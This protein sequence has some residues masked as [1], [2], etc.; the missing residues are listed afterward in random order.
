MKKNTKNVVDTS[1][2]AASSD[3]A[4]VN[5]PREGLITEIKVRFAVTASGAMSA[6]QPGGLW[7]AIQNL[8]IEGDG[9]FGFLGLSGEE[10]GRI[11]AF[12]NL[13]DFGVPLITLQDGTGESIT[14]VFHP[15]S[16]PKDPFDLS[17][18][19]P[20]RALSTLQAKITTTANTVLDD[21]QTI[22]SGTYYYEVSHVLEAPVPAGLMVPR[23]STLTYSHDA[24]HSDYSKEIDVPAGAF[25][26]R[27]FIV[28]QDEAT[29]KPLQAE[30]EISGVKLRVAKTNVTILQQLWQELK[31]SSGAYSNYIGAPFQVA[32]TITGHLNLLNGYACIDL[33][34]YFD[35]VYGLDLRNAQTGDV[36]L[37]LTIA[38]YTSGDDTLLYFDQLGPVDPGYVGR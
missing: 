26:R 7:R 33:R 38:N 18:A 12:W 20:A 27:I 4:G 6:V 30:D 21:S 29:P 11:L 14:W 8:K 35:P 2:W 25:L 34:K 10:T 15:G 19:I 24:A 9:G 13:L 16:N 32:D 22:S 1:T 28:S 23:G 5:L 3:L 37:G 31:A 17:A 36:K